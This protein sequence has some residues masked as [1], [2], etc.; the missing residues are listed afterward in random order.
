MK[1]S[2]FVYPV[3]T[4][5]VQIFVTKRAFITFKIEHENR[6]FRKSL[7]FYILDAGKKK[8]NE[9][10]LGAGITLNQELTYIIVDTGENGLRALASALIYITAIYLKTG[11]TENPLADGPQT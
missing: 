3:K 8:K 4:I 6:D 1:F 2:G 5:A 11:V 7:Y 9:L 10:R